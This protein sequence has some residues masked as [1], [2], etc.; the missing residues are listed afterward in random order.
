MYK[1]YLSPSNQMHN[2]CQ[3]GDVEGKHCPQLAAMIGERLAAKGFA[4]KIRTPTNS[5]TANMA[6][7]KKWGADLY[8]PLHTN[9]A[10]AGARGT[11]F[12]YYG[13]RADSKAA[14]E[15]FKAVWQRFYPLPDKVK[16]C[17][18][19][20]FG[21]AKRPH[22]PSVYTEQ[23]FHSN[24]DDA[25]LLHEH[26]PE[27]ADAMVE[28]IEAYFAAKESGTFPTVLVTLRNG[29]K[30]EPVRELQT[31]LNKAGAA[32]KVD[33][34]FGPLTEEA[35]KKYQASQKIKADGICGP[36]TWGKIKQA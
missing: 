13:P 2:R 15:V 35:L 9:A 11:R 1:V 8:I 36:A 25:K 24:P 27:C 17:E 26:M 20:N 12:G 14:C 28:C 16:T 30:G 4:F 32:L 31:A 18:Y 10:G 3:Y 7:A 19:N 6:E 34:S 21:E 22:C 23:L 33:G 29:S 5:L